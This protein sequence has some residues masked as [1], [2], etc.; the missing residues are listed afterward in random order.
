MPVLSPRL[1]SLWE[2][3]LV[4]PIPAELARPL[5]DSLV[6]EVVVHDQAID[7][8]VPREPIGCREAIELALRRIGE[9]DVSTRWT[10]AEMYG[11]TPADPMPTD[12]EW[13]GATMLTDRLV[14]PATQRSSAR[15]RVGATRLSSATRCGY[16]EACWIA[17]GGVGMRRGRRHP[18][19]LRVG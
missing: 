11:R 3:G 5:I 15:V 8:V 1:S 17:V 14:I 4:T 19:D 13:A 18:T 12:P 16:C 9:V 7:D 6:N 2:V 10:D